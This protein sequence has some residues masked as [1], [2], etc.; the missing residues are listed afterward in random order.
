[1]YRSNG[2]TTL[3]PPSKIQTVSILL[4]VDLNPGKSPN[5]MDIATTVEPRNV[6]HL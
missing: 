3:V 2:T 5:Y 1:M 6:R 4:Q